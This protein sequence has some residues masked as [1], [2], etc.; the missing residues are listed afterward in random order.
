MQVSSDRKC[1]VCGPENRVGLN[2]TFLVDSGLNSAETTLRLSES[3]QGWQ[4]R[5]H[6]GIISALLDEAA[7]YACRPISLHAVTATLAVKFR[8]PVAVD[9]EIKVKAKVRQIRRN[10]AFVESILTCDGTVAAEAEVTV[11]LLKNGGEESNE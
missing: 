1:F 2:A 10:V 11:I 6:G 7:I 5:V 4:G 9:V 3:H 8:Q